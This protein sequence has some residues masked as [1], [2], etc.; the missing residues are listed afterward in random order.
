MTNTPRPAFCG[1][2]GGSYHRIIAEFPPHE[3]YVEP[4]AGSAA[5]YRHKAPA[6]T[7]H[8]VEIEEATFQRLGKVP[9]N[10]VTTIYRADALQWLADSPVVTHPSGRTLIYADPPYPLSTLSDRCRYE[11]SLT[12]DQHV[13]LLGL[14]KTAVKAGC[15]V[16]ISTYDNP[17]YQQQLAGWRTVRYD[18]ATRGG[19]REETLYL[20][21]AAPPMLHDLRYLGRDRRER[22]KLTRRRKNLIRKLQRLPALERRQLLEA[23]Q[24]TFAAEMA[25][26]R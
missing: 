8:L 11:H 3:V 15:Y 21:Y 5:V 22:E 24:S 14:L 6:G 23:L 26:G 1:G 10:A 18:S 4:F 12:D 20:S 25:V 7:S 9:L 19:M 2:K 16:A 17:I 13:Q